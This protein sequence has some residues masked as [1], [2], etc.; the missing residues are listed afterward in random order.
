MTFELKSSFASFVVLAIVSACG[1]SKPP[2]AEAAAAELVQ[3]S[4]AGK[5]KGGP[6]VSQELGSI[7]PQEADRV[8]QSVQAKF[9]TCQK[10]G[11]K[12]VGPLSG[13]VK[14]FV[15]IGSDGKAKYVVLEDSTLGDLETESCMMHAVESA[16][17]PVPRGGNE[18]EARK[19]YGFDAGD[20]RPPAVWGPDKIEAAIAKHQKDLQNCTAGVKGSFKVTLYVEAEKKDGKAIA[21][22]VAAP[23]HEAQA[24]VACIADVVKSMKLPSPGGY[25]AKSTFSL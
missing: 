4:H 23:N 9:Q 3:E 2:E 15:R 5:S 8:F 12:R 10:A 1:G 6:S 14:F 17:W 16:S 22:G 24:K 21:V 19:G 13:D 25:L 7:D 20:E 18:A 11:M